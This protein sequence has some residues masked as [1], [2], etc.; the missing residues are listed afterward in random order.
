MVKKLGGAILRKPR[1]NDPK[2]GNFSQ[3]QRH[4]KVPKHNYF[5]IIFLGHQVPPPEIPLYQYQSNMANYNDFRGR[6]KS[7]FF[8]ATSI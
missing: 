2:M 3:F 4:K 8:A 1:K 7:T 6:Q 5:Y